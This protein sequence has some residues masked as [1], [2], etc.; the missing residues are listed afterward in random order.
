[1]AEYQSGR[2]QQS[3][4]MYDFTYRVAPLLPPP[5]DFQQLLGAVHAHPNAMERFIRVTSC[6]V[7]AAD[8]FSEES[9][10]RI[11]AQRAS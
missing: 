3:M 4:P 2:D 1:M 5:P 8:F 6:V 7:S 10:Q 9:V 11:F